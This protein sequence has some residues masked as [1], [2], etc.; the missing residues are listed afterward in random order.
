MPSGMQQ[1]FL[2]LRLLS[3]I[4]I[5]GGGLAGHVGNSESWQYVSW[6][7]SIEIIHI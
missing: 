5:P 4:Y 7:T 6:A 1:D 3:L 2:K